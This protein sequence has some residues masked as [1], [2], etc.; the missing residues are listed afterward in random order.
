MY[1]QNYVEV[2]EKC[3][4]SISDKPIVRK[5]S[6]ITPTATGNP[7]G[8]SYCWPSIPEL[9]NNG[10]T[11]EFTGLSAGEGGRT[12]NWLETPGLIPNGNTAQFTGQYSGN[13]TV[14]VI[15]TPLG[16]EESC[17]VEKHTITITAECSVIL[18][19][20]SEIN[21]GETT[22]FTAFGS[23]EGGSYIWLGMEDLIKGHNTAQFT[24]LLKI[25]KFF[26]LSILIFILILFKYT[27]STGAEKFPI[28]VMTI[29]KSQ[30]KYDNP[31]NA[32]IASYS[33]EIKK[34]LDW[35]FESMTVE[36]S[37]ELKTIFIKLKIPLSQI[38]KY[39]KK[40]EETYIINKLNYK[41]GFLLIV[42]HNYKEGS[43]Q[44]NPVTFVLENGEWKLTNKFSSDENVNQYM[45]YH[46]RST[47]DT[48][49]DITYS[50]VRYNRRTRQF[51]S[52]VTITNTSD[53]ELEGPVWLI[54]KNLQPE[55]ASMANADGIHFGEP[56]VILL[57]EEK[58]WPPGQA[59]PAKTLYFN[60]PVKQRLNF[61][62]QV[63]AVVPDEES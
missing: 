7:G 40:E 60:N 8:G 43:I 36:A 47:L 11:A 6:N 15:Y 21:L 56:Y 44:R 61:D 23:E 42:E 5:G 54:I 30:A 41:K 37:E 22:T 45:A 51:Y 12:F 20:P 55:E 26:N 59:L 16:E 34:D 24:G 1:Y 13:S 10:Q 32:Y 62:D 27:I 4:V 49:I 48:Q 53:K 52:A 35:T 9:V 28:K 17:L 38:I 29:N 18:N 57:G 46:E 33:S 58:K 19:G 31:E 3:A 63:F 50:G 14:G 39:E 25:I 2:V